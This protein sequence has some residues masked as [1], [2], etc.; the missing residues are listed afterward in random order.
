[1]KK[2][3]SLTKF[4]RTSMVSCE[5]PTELLE[6]VE[7]HRKM[8]HCSKSDVIRWALYEYLD[9]YMEVHRT[10]KVMRHG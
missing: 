3:P 5:L 2:T 7:D 8:L 1:M 4:R 9:K 10:K 6:G